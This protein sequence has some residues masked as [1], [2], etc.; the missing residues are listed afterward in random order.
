[1]KKTI[2]S[3]AS[4]MMLMVATVMTSCSKDDDV[5]AH[6]ENVVT[7]TVHMP[8]EAQSRVSVIDDGTINLIDWELGDTVKVYNVQFN[9]DTGRI[10]VTGGHVFRC[11]DLATYTFTGILPEG[12]TLQD[13]NVAV[14]GHD[15]EPVIGDMYVGFHD[16]KVSTNLKDVIF[17]AGE[18][19]ADSCILDIRNNVIRVINENAPVEVAWGWYDHFVKPYCLL[20]VENHFSPSADFDV[21]KDFSDVK[22]TIPT[23][24]SYVFMPPTVSQELGLYDSNRE[25]VVRKETFSGMPRFTVGKIFDPSSGDHGS[26]DPGSGDPGPIVAG[27]VGFKASDFSVTDGAN[28]IRAEKE[29]INIVISRTVGTFSLDPSGTIICNNPDPG[30]VMGVSV[31]SSVGNIVRVSCSADGSIPLEGE[32]DVST[33]NWT[34]KGSDEGWINI[35]GNKFMDLY[36]FTSQT[37]TVEYK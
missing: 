34:L 22:F 30:E 33:C 19:T 2:W 27:S 3:L 16:K 12:K 13:Y 24:I 31:S 35:N 21:N 1:M 8:E 11:T 25:P 37:I 15:I 14:Y 6:K 29:G 36:L 32:D 17:L 18:I 23:G 4:L 28:Y 7:L 20:D 9:N 10:E 26:D 5:V